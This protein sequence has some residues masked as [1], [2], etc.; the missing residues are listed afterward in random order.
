MPVTNTRI[1]I[2]KKNSGR[3][4]VGLREVKK[5]EKKSGARKRW[6]WREAVRAEPSSLLTRKLLD[7]APIVKLDISNN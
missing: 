4:K 7:V 1:S 3:A 5:T 6:R 2:R